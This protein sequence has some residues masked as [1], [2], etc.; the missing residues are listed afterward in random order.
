M[1]GTWIILYSVF[2]YQKQ[3]Y[4]GLWVQ[5]T[6]NI[7]GSQI[8]PSA[9]MSTLRE[10]QKGVKNQRNWTIKGNIFMNKSWKSV[11]RSKISWSALQ[12]YFSTV[13]QL[14]LR[15]VKNVTLHFYFVLKPT[16]YSFYSLWLFNNKNYK[17]INFINF[18]REIFNNKVSQYPQVFTLL[19]T[20]VK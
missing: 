10:I 18:L 4:E 6:K 9:L 20:S 16:Y 14:S 1:A 7:E 13:N 15:T 17:N 2:S 11:A 8:V 5:I 12:S 19:T 3:W